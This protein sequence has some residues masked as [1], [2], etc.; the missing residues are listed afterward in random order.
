VPSSTGSSG[1][2]GTHPSLKKSLAYG[3]DLTSQVR[4]SPTDGFEYNFSDKASTCG[5]QKSRS[6]QQ[7][8]LGAGHPFGEFRAGNEHYYEQPM[9]VF[10]PASNSST[11]HSTGEAS[12]ACMFHS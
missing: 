1:P 3:P 10:P 8:L 11:L 5:S 4:H 9:V 2:D 12:N 6:V 7:P